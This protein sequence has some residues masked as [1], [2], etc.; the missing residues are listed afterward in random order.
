MDEAPLAW[1]LEG[2]PAIR[3]QVMRDLQGLPAREFVAEQEKVGASGWGRRL[4]DAQSADGRWATDRGPRAYRGLYA[5]KWTS[6]TYTLL[7]LRRLGLRP[8][9]TAALAGC[10]ALVQRSQWF[11]DGSIGPWAAKKTDMCVCA[12]ILGILEYFEHDDEE[13]RD[14]LVH[15]LLTHEK[16]DGGWNCRDASHVSSMHTTLSVLEAF[17][18]RRTH[19]PN[20]TIDE[21]MR[22]GH[23]Y[24]CQRGLFRSLRTG[25]VIQSNF[26]KISFPPR[27][28]YDVLRALDHFQGAEAPTDPRLQEAVDI[29]KRRR[30]RDGKWPVQNRHPGE[31]LFEMEKPGASSRWN[32]LRALRVLRWWGT[33]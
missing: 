19:A 9:H 7:L 31:S 11:D 3:W 26:L 24:L 25:R 21:A 17:Q 18:I 23:E 27:W 29:V 6:T 12:M 10:D 30:K 32:T 8:K 2:D 13:K 16:S 5:P 15:F 22:R 14:G 20:K 28:R 33:A 1:L 4:L